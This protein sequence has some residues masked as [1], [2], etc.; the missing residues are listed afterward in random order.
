M[1]QGNEH[2]HLSA[3]K[4]ANEEHL[5][6]FGMGLQAAE[7]LLAENLVNDPFVHPLASRGDDATSIYPLIAKETATPM[8]S[9]SDGQRSQNIT[10]RGV[11][12]RS[13]TPLPNDV[14]IDVTQKGNDDTDDAAE[15][16]P[17]VAEPSGS[18]DEAFELLSAYLDDEVT[19]DERGLVEHWLASDPELQSHYQKQLRLRQ[20]LK[21][22]MRKQ[23]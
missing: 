9:S 8:G 2:F 7:N 10:A 3:P 16:P 21:V 11:A 23:P 14:D 13:I 4:G 17:A 19:D 15:P 20:A 1:S 12:D 22:F 5:A 18:V 6:G